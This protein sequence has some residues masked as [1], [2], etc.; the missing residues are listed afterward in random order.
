MELET[1][2]ANWKNDP[3]LG[4]N[5]VNWKTFPARSADLRDFPNTIVPKL[6]DQLKRQGV[7][8]LFSHQLKAWNLIQNGQNV[9]LAT[10]TASGKSLAYQLPILNTLH[11]DPQ[12]TALLLFPT[13]ALARDQL[14]WFDDYPIA[15]AQVYDGD[16]PQ[17][18]RKAI[19]ESA[20]III[21]NPDMLHLGILPYHTKWIEFLSRLSYIVVDEIHVYRGVF[22]SHVA[23]VIRRLKRLVGHYG[24]S[25]RFLLT[26]ATIGNPKELAEALISDSF[27]VVEKDASP[28]GEKHF[29]LYNPPVIDQKLGL[30]AS[31][32][33]ESVR[34][35]SDLITGGLQT[36]IFGRSRRSVEFTLSQLKEQCPLPSDTL[37]AYR[38]GYLASHRRDLEN[39]LR[40]G[41]IRGIAAT[42]ALELGID[43]GGLDAAI[44][45]GYPGSVAGTWQQA[46]RAGRSEKLSLAVLVASSHPLDQYLA[47]YPEYLFGTN[48]ENG[49]IDADNLLI[50]L[51]HIQC[52]A[53]ELPFSEGSSYG[54]LTPSQTREILEIIQQLGKLHLSNGTYYWMSD[55]YPSAAISLRSTSSDQV[56]LQL[57]SSSGKRSVL[58][59]VDYES[60]LWMVH[61]GAIYLHAGETFLVDDLDLETKTAYLS[62][63]AGDYYTEAEKRTEFTLNH[64]HSQ[65]SISGGTKYFGEIQVTSQVTGYKRINWDHYEILSRESVDLPSTRLNTMGMWV[66]ISEETEQLLRESG[67]WSSSPNDYGPAWEETRLKVL[68]RDRNRCRNCGRPA[69]SASL[70]VHHKVPLR[71]F[72][73]YREANQLDNLISL[74]PRCHQRAETIVRINSGISG[75]G[76]ILHSLAPLLLM[77]DPGDLGIFTDFQSPF[78]QKRPIALLY[79]LIPAG[80]GFSKHLYREFDRLI[81][82]AYQAVSSCGCKNGCPS[83]V[84]PGGDIAAGGKQETL[85]I[86]SSLYS[87]SRD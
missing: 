76:H 31:M 69:A 37:Q 26:S 45:A 73:S 72:P 25:P 3:S 6:R 33:S 82:M 55:E 79:E 9:V 13:K 4:P 21:S 27:S 41:S 15:R 77:C 51:A 50:I 74:C 48:P 29:I 60:A 87:D 5:I 85:A 20:N 32:Q 54:S 57:S 63:A 22:G 14:E 46:G 58:G 52:A 75:L 39:K 62:P 78:D 61:P 2:L 42:T 47:S 10:G 44:L 1:I 53:Y 8:A 28:R 68:A 70:H 34:L 40:S 43:I 56:N 30:R 83:C 16:T 23:N 12:S 18:Q 36:I 84:G 19:R 64:L 17:N 67:L 35:A 24:A 81:M 11:Q 86:L 71:A 66:T 38:S 7:T 59:T 80:I 65:D 49:L